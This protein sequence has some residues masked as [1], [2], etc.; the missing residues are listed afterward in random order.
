[1]FFSEKINN[2]HPEKTPQTSL[3]CPS[4][5]IRLTASLLPDSPFYLF[6]RVFPQI[7]ATASTEKDFIQMSE[8]ANALLTLRLRLNINTK[9]L[10]LNLFV[11]ICVILL[12]RP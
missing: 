7:K 4:S 11:C 10:F 1:M 5:V 8:T 2:F 9:H 3:A 12:E 6:S